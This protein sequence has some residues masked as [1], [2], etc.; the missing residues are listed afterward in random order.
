M[1]AVGGLEW[2]EGCGGFPGKV[3]DFFKKNSFFL[4]WQYF[5]PAWNDFIE[6][7][8]IPVQVR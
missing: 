5:F 1:L 8:E 3:F 4:L 2:E 6:L 7:I